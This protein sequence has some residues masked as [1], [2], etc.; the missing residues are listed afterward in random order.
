MT[1]TSYPKTF[2]LTDLQRQSFQLLKE[3][4]CSSKLLFTARYDR[5][6][7][8]SADA[9]EYAVAACLAQLNDSSH[10]APIAYASSKLTDTQRRWSTVEKESYAVV[11]ALEKFSTII[12]GCHI[13]LYSDHNP[14]QYLMSSAPKSS[15]LIRWVM[16]LAKYDL[17]V[18]HRPGVQ[19]IIPDCLSRL[20]SH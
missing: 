12:Y 11:F 10:E 2:T 1:K 5:D 7:I 4:L 9:S 3:T 8:V 20:L 6:F 16:G 19:N 17:E 13:I 18:R 14:L 15:K